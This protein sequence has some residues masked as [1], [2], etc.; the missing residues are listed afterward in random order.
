MPEVRDET[1]RQPIGHIAREGSAVRAKTIGAA[2]VAGGVGAVGAPIPSVGATI[3][4]PGVTSS[5]VS[6]SVAGTS[7]GGAWTSSI[8]MVGA[9]E[10][11]T[12]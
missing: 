4:S 1:E 6:A 10:H 5:A 2:G 8:V 3:P 9:W 7:F 12:D 11:A